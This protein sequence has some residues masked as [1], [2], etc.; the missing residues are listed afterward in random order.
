M[1]TLLKMN[2]VAVVMDTVEKLT[3][4][5]FEEED[6]SDESDERPS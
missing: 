2:D 4:A 3:N 1:V 5:L 6:A